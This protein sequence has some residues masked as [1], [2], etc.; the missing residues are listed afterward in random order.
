MMFAFGTVLLFSIVQSLFGM[1]LLVFGTPTLLLLGFD[2]YQTLATLLPASIIIS[3]LQLME[4]PTIERRFAKHFAVWCLPPLGLSLAALSVYGS[5]ISLELVIGFLLLF[6]ASFQLVP[7]LA[8]RT[9][10]FV[11]QNSS[12]W[13][14]VMGMVHGV[15]NLGGG[16]LS[17]V[18]RA[19]FRDKVE[20]RHSIAFCYFC[21]ASVQLLIL[22][23]FKP[24]YFDWS[25]L[26][27]MILAGA[28]YLTVG[29]R[30][31][32]ILPQVVF[33]RLFLAFMYA[34]GLALI[35][36]SFV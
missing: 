28:V 36:R 1:G 9:R 21:F 7:Q 19:Y 18:A 16:V 4:N 31:F 22:F 17:V 23:I 3:C 8:A 34:Y 29:R 14:V 15:S 11:L 30:T 26:L 6:F 5:A 35:A 12:A 24:A 25:N 13:M 33:E 20:V 32:E 10:N 2:F 27:V